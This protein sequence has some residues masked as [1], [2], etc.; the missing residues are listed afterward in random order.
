MKKFGLA[1]LG[2]TLV[3]L[4]AVLLRLGCYGLNHQAAPGAEFVVAVAA[5][6]SRARC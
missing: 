4:V 5:L 2:G 6:I 1:V 3:V